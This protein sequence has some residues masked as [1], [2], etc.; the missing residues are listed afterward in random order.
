MKRTRRREFLKYLVDCGCDVNSTLGTIEV[1]YKG[2]PAFKVSDT[3]R[4]DIQIKGD[5]EDLKNEGVDIDN[6]YKKIT[7]YASL[8]MKSKFE[9]LGNEND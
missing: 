8:D 1:Y 6:F 3:A 4:F 5:I 9:E 2:S 7:D